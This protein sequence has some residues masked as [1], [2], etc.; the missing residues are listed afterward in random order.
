[1]GKSEEFT[2]MWYCGFVKFSERARTND[3][4]RNF[5]ICEYVNWSFEYAILIKIL[6][7]SKFVVRTER[8]E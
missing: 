4:E 3:G 1:M 7:R 6:I 2:A 5:A 8:L